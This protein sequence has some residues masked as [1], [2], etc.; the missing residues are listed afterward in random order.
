[1][2]GLLLTFL[3][4]C[5]GENACEAYVNSYYGCAEEAGAD[6]TGIDAETLCANYEKGTADDYYNCMA[7]AYSNADC[8]TAEGVT[9][10]NT[11]AAACVQ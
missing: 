9:A 5:G 8:S 2:I 10:A 11:D 4:A 3:V 6:T 1:M 7:D